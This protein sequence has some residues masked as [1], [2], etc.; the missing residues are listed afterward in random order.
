MLWMSGVESRKHSVARRPLTGPQDGGAAGFPVVDPMPSP[1]PAGIL[2]Q[3]HD[4]VI[5]TDM[6]GR[7]LTWNPAA[8]RMYGYT[9][10]EAVGQHVSFLHFPEDAGSW[11]EQVLAPTLAKG[12][13]ET[14]LRNRRKDGEE[15]YV[16]LRL[17]VQRD[18][19]GQA[20]ALIGCSNDVTERRRAADALRRQREEQQIILDA[21]PAMVWYK[22]R[23]NRILRANRAAAASV[24]KTVAE[25]SGASTY[26]L[27]PEEA[28]QYHQDD[29]DVIRSGVAKLGIVE[30]LDTGAGGKRWI[31][32]DKIPYRDERGEIV[33]VIVF[34]VD[35]TELKHAEAALERSRDE[36][37]QRVHE[38]TAALSAAVDSLRDEIAERQQ[39]EDRLEVALWASDLGLW[40]WDTTTNRVIYDRRWAEMLGYAPAD[41]VPDL[42]AWQRIVH[43]DDLPAV[44]QALE[45]MLGYAPEEIVPDLSTVPHRP[46]P[47]VPPPGDATATRRPFG[48]V[49][50]RLRT[51]SGEYRWV[52]TRGKVVQWG[53][54]G[55]A[56]RIAG[57]NRD[58]TNRKQI[59]ERLRQQQAELA[60]VL[61]RRPSEGWRQS[62]RTRSISRSAPSPTTPT[63][64]S[65]ACA[66]NGSTATR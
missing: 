40:D 37:E 17:V 49:E 4:G 52:L 42:A 19:D 60:H 30:Q 64:W 58:I 10:E 51:K 11:E 47:F 8:E 12:L 32:T 1:G 66:R 62:W 48:E 3:I 16:A 25:L 35:L 33:G 43:P 29:L 53:A 39:T 46:P 13:H 45:A 26:D 56:R 27:Y 9:A 41:I 44:R 15:I 24:H 2:A 50:Q 20:T 23:H 31:R 28:A 59:E 21:M 63:G 55:R 18:G 57:T 14:E 36:L 5:T 22:D 7:V 6:C 65:S 34:A 38:R 54:D 61:R